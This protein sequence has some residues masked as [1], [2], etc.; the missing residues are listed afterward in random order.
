VLDVTALDREGNPVEWQTGPIVWGQPGTNGQHAYYQLIHQGTKLLPCDFIG[1]CKPRHDVGD[2]QNLLLANFFADRLR[3]ARSGRSRA[4][5]A[6]FRCAP[7]VPGQSPHHH[8]PG[9]KLTPY[10]P[11]QLVRCMNTRCSR[12]TIWNIN[13][14]DQ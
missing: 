13:S 10:V 11:R 6:R 7:Y 3:S 2:H 14:F 5:G 4:A 8:D 9:K 12:G 1:F